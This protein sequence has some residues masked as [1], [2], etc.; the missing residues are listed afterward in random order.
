MNLPKSLIEE[1]TDYIIDNI[2][3]YNCPDIQEL[4]H[5]LFNTD[6]Y[7]IGY[8]QAEQWL[9][10]HFSSFFDMVNLVKEYE[11]EQFGETGT[12]LNMDNSEGYANAISYIAGAQILYSLS[13]G[14]VSGKVLVNRIKYE[15][16]HGGTA[17]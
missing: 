10:K 9:N 5:A 17:W 2:D 4:H 12:F 3:G 11:L 8:Y 7:I 6:Y 13:P 15:L 1:I 16:A 14:D